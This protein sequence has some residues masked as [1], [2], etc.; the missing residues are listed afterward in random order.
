MQITNLHQAK[1]QLSN[2]VEKAYMGEEVI[3]C[4]AGKPMARLVKYQLPQSSRIPGLWKGK[5]IMTDD[6]D[7][8]PESLCGA[9][10]NG[11]I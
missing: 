11:K 9:F 7:I 3:I 10:K 6:F 4:K 5:V 1:A 2:L 8:L